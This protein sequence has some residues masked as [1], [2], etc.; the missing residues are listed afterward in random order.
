MAKRTM[1]APESLGGSKFL[2]VPGTYLFHVVD[3]RDGKMVG[4]EEKLISGFSMSLQV[5]AG[6]HAGK[7]FNLTL[8]DAK[9][10]DKDEGAF[11]RKKQFAFCVAAD[12]L[13]PSDLG[14]PVSYDPE[15]GKERFIVARLEKGRDERYLDLS[16]SDIFHVDDPRAPKHERSDDV[17]SL[18][19]KQ[20]RHDAAYFDALKKGKPSNGA[21]KAAAGLSQSQLDSL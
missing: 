20:F 21:T 11:A 12:L 19:Q 7:E 15:D 2:D 6:E 13:K 10:T 17:L 5:A 18:I 16:Y 9:L 14:K 4:K 3:V 8:F 1:D